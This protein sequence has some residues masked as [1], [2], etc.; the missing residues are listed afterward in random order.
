MPANSFHVRCISLADQGWLLALNN[1]AVPAV[2]TLTDHSLRIILENAAWVRAIDWRG[3][4]AGVLIAFG[5]GAA[6]ES[7]NYRWFNER[8]QDFLY[9]DRII[10]DPQRRGCG[11][12]RSLYAALETAAEDLANRLTCEVNEYP[13]NPESLRFHISAGFA[14]IGRQVLDGGA[15]RVMLMEKKLTSSPAAQGP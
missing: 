5:P 9:V 2:N 13:S 8:F 6:Y 12:G 7:P 4:P 15:K 14:V 3:T 1:A 10:V 11:I